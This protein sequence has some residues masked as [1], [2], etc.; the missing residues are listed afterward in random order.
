MERKDQGVISGVIKDD[1]TLGIDMGLQLEMVIGR[2]WSAII[3]GT[4]EL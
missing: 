1:M 4:L 3:N 2:N